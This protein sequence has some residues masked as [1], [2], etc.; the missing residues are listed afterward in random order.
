MNSSTLSVFCEGKSKRIEK[1]VSQS[2]PVQTSNYSL[3]I[4]QWIYQQKNN[5]TGDYY[6]GNVF[7]EE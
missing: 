1:K 3:L 6:L 2:R 5:V 7:F 4:S